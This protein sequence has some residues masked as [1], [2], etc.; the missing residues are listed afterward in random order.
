MIL[1]CVTCIVQVNEPGGSCNLK[2]ALKHNE[3]TVLGV[4]DFQEVVLKMIPEK[5]VNNK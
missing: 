3:D 4:L 1:S 5:Q 2:T